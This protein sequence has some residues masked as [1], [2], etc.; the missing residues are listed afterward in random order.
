M[1][2]THAEKSWSRA[3]RVF[4]ASP[5]GVGLS[6]PDM[7]HAGGMDSVSEFITPIARLVELVF[8]MKGALAGDPLVIFGTVLK[9]DG[10][11]LPEKATNFGTFGY[12]LI[13]DVKRAVE[14]EIQDAALISA[15]R[16][17]PPDT[18]A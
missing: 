14:S 5:L 11:E 4:F 10:N 6:V 15:L 8:D 9:K 2:G 1:R 16:A 3:V 18:D 12:L 13:I 17:V 7:V